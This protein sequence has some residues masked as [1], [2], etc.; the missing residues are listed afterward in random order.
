MNNVVFRKSDMK[1]YELQELQ[2]KIVEIVSIGECKDTALMYMKNT[3]NDDIYV[4]KLDQDFRRNKTHMK[5]TCE[6]KHIAFQ[7]QKILDRARNKCFKELEKKYGTYKG[8]SKVDLT[9]SFLT[10]TNDDFFK[11]Y[12]F[13]YIPDMKLQDSVRKILYGSES[14]QKTIT[15]DTTKIT[16]E[17]VENLMK[18]INRKDYIK[19]L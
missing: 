1:T 9:K 3:E 14:V 4:V 2:G 15:V 11:L 19:E 13:N 6:T 16:S 7:D 17:V 5:S 10:M 18:L 12:G 8:Y